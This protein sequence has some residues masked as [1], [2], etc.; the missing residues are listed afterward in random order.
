[1]LLSKNTAELGEVLEKKVQEL[2]RNVKAKM[3]RCFI[4]M[5]EG[6][7]LYK[8]K[9]PFGYFA[10]YPLH[11]VCEKGHEWMYEGKAMQKEVNKGQYRIPSV[12]EVFDIEELKKQNWENWL[13]KHEDKTEPI[14]QDQDWIQ[15]EADLES[16]F[17]QEGDAE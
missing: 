10:E 5:D 15:I 6:I 1:M 8:K 4:C 13:K 12:D 17:D 16:I 9:T 7:I 2:S 11:C 3:P 14:V